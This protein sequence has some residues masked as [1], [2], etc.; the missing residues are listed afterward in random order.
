MAG[1]SAAKEITV[2]KDA[3]A[4]VEKDAV[5]TVEKEA[6]VTGPELKKAKLQAPEPPADLNLNPAVLTVNEVDL[7][8]TTVANLHKYRM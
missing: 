4:M 1:N 3:V 6:A 2:E 7:P 8:R 5:T